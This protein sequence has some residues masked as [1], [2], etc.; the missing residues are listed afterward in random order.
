MTQKTAPFVLCAL[1]AFSIWTRDATAQTAHPNALPAQVVGVFSVPTGNVIVLG[2]DGRDLYLP[3]W[4]A[5]REAQVA[6]SY[7]AGQQIARPLTHDLLLSAITTLGGRVTRV[8]V[9]DLQGRTF[10]GRIDL[11]ERGVARQLDA[12]SSDAICVGLGARVPILVMMHV[13]AQAGL[14]R[15]QLQQQGITL[16]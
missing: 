9:S 14:S 8:L 15:T 13:L 4:V 16:P 12:R 1:L 7:L 5:D 2:V 6:R 10:V 11:V 3:I